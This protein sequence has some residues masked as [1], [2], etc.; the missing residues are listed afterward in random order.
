MALPIAEEEQPMY[1]PYEIERKVLD[2]F[3]FFDDT[4]LSVEDVHDELEPYD[5][6]QAEVVVAM[7]ALA[8]KGNIGNYHNDQ[9]FYMN[10]H[11]GSEEQDN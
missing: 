4:S 7:Q 3:K 2:L 5:I 10:D 11:D 8:D 6:K 1:T 9:W